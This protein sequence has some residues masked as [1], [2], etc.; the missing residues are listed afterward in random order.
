MT[1]PAPPA[2]NGDVFVPVLM[3]GMGAYLLWFGVRYWRGQG[4][5]VWPSYPVK[6]VLQGQ[7]V[8][9]NQ[10]ASSSAA[11]VTAYETSAIISQNTSATGSTAPAATASGSAQNTAQMLLGQFGWGVD[12]MAALI[13]LWTRESGWNPLAKNASS[14]A[15]GIAQALGHGTPG[16]AGTDSDEYGA[17]YGLTTAQAQAANSGSALYQILWGL[18][19]IK[20]RYGSPDAAWAHEEAYGWY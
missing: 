5:A 9:A 6:S 3:L 11:S 15:F 18:G 19:Y 1:T 2:T 17:E 16:S 14:G 20:S 12:Q 8:P 4:A 7:G 13:A 10:Q